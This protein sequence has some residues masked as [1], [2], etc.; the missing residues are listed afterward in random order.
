MLLLLPKKPQVQ[1]NVTAVTVFIASVK[2]NF[3]IYLLLVIPRPL[4]VFFAD[5][6]ER[7]GVLSP[8]NILSFSRKNSSTVT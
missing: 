7:C 8:E 3:L 5:K 6:L 2:H 1:H 4:L